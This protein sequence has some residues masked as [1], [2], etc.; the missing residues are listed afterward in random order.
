MKKHRNNKF[1]FV[2]VII[3][4][5]LIFTILLLLLKRPH[6][7][8]PQEGGTIDPNAVYQAGDDIFRAAISE[9]AWFYYDGHLIK[10]YDP[11]LKKSFV[12]C[13]RSNCRHNSKECDAWFGNDDDGESA[14]VGVAT[15]GGY[16][17]VLSS[18]E[19]DRSFDRER[20]VNY[21]IIKIDLFDGTR[22]V[23]QEFNNSIYAQPDD[24]KEY[25]SHF[26]SGNVYVCNGILWLKSQLMSMP[27]ETI[28]DA[29]LQWTQNIGVD[30]N[31]GKTIIIG[32]RDS[33]CRLLTM[34]SGYVTYVHDEYDDTVLTREK[35]YDL[36]TEIGRVEYNGSTYNNYTDYINAVKNSSGVTCKYYLYHLNDGT[37]EELF[38]SKTV[39]VHSS[40]G[41]ESYTNQ[42]AQKSIS[43]SHDNLILIKELIPDEKGGYN[44]NHF[45]AS[46]YNIQ[47]GSTEEILET[48]NGHL[49]CSMIDGL[50]GI[51]SDGTVIVYQYNEDEALTEVWIY[52]I[53]TKDY[54]YLYTEQKIGYI[55]RPEGVWND[56][57][58]GKLYQLN[59]F[60]EGAHGDT[61]P[62]LYAWISR[63]DY[64]S[65]NMNALVRYKIK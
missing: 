6:G 52:N 48:E 42:I 50:N 40:Y 15:E 47:D 51:L 49:P 64:L 17:Y 27:N 55:F 22:K 61:I 60:P 34:G 20:P 8:V 25:L 29:R 63:E 19:T 37:T 33:E 14:I 56:G 38:D 23:I 18:G 45:R 54:K 36:L 53:I 62:M 35:F 32:S 10:Y 16:V 1:I 46:L 24:G 4:I 44:F 28:E 26:Y 65:G 43:G 21:Q 7:S 3:I 41:S 13:A 58:I 5:V 2:A 57:F 11:A 31:T 12:L 39:P 30:L 9:S 59:G